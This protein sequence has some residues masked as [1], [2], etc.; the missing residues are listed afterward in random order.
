MFSPFNL[1]PGALDLHS[2]TPE[3]EHIYNISR[4]RRLE[5]TDL[6][7][8]LDYPFSNLMRTMA[9][10][11]HL[12]SHVLSVLSPGK[13]LYKKIKM[14]EPLDLSLLSDEFR[15][16]KE[17]S[18]KDISTWDVEKVVEFVSEL[19]ECKD[20]A[21]IFKREEIDGSCLVKLSLHHLTTFLGIKIGP[22]VKLLMVLHDRRTELKN[23]LL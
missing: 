7:E 14:E 8:H 12:R 6:L 18:F 23:E 22:A 21:P 16:D 2:V 19:E 13:N 3:R 20:Y 17:N 15:M 1:H 4:K 11:H 10:R 5:E 9:A